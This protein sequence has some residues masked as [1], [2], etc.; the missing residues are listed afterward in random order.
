MLMIMMFKIAADGED[1]VIW[2]SLVSRDRKFVGLKLL[3]RPLGLGWGAVFRRKW[4]L[5]VFEVLCQVGLWIMEFLLGAFCT[6]LVWLLQLVLVVLFF[7]LALLVGRGACCCVRA[8][9][10]EN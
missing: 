1:S 2:E 3:G 6:W 4:K 5:V 9:L 8:L 10:L 7:F